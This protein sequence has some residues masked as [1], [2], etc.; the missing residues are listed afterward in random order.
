M[1]TFTAGFDNSAG[2]ADIGCHRCHDWLAGS[3]VE[4][5][6][7]KEFVLVISMWGHTGAEW[8]YVGNQIVL[9][10]SFT[11]EQ[12]YRLLQKDMWTANYKN[13]FYKMNIQCFPKDC[14]GK[15]VCD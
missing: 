5:R 4:L 12:C 11:Q 14:A 6:K 10:Q 2:F 13:Q 9:Q 8:M 15:R 3:L 7:M 1:G